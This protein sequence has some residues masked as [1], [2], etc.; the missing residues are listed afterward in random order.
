MGSDTW[1]SGKQKEEQGLTWAVPSLTY[2]EL[3]L[4]RENISYGVLI[5]KF[6]CIVFLT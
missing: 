6:N 4:D 3:A 2:P 5:F 1:D